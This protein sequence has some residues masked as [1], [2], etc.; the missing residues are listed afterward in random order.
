MKFANVFMPPG[1]GA[2]LLLRPA[3]PARAR[4]L[5]LEL[6]IRE[7]NAPRYAL[8]VCAETRKKKLNVEISGIFS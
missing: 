5:K 4:G 3:S 7:R 1:L 8:E 6:G 2:S